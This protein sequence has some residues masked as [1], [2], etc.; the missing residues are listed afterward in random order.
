MAIYIPEEQYVGFN[1]R[2]QSTGD[3][4]AEGQWITEDVLLGF[5][6]PVSADAAFKKRKDTVDHWS[7]GYRNK[8]L[9]DPRLIPKTFKNELAEGFEIARSVRRS[10]WN[11]GNV[12][13]RV[14]DP[15]GFELEISS[16]NFASIVDCATIVNGVIQGRCVWGRDGA[17]NV[18]LPENSEPYQEFAKLTALKNQAQAGGVGIRDIKPGYII[19]LESG[20]E[21]EYLGKFHCYKKTYDT[22]LGGR[23]NDTRIE[24]NYYNTTV[25]RFMYKVKNG[26]SYAV[27]HASRLKIANIVDS[28]NT[29]A[30]DDNVALINEI[31]TEFVHVSVKKP[32]S[33]IALKLVPVDLATVVTCITDAQCRYDNVYIGR[34]GDE[35]VSATSRHM[36][37]GAT[38]TAKVTLVENGYG[39]ESTRSGSYGYGFRHDQVA[40]PSD[41]LTKYEWFQLVV[42][43][44]DGGTYEPQRYYYSR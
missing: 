44:D 40:R 29:T 10:G 19:T 25:E 38:K 4:N 23:W 3:K 11:S 16:S 14:V 39:T 7:R 1:L 18:L 26:S 31:G 30:L 42:H 9:D 28:S 41:D 2:S 15:R 5:A 6:T 32:T 24:Y 27:Q 43:F 12:V 22:V 21:V 36:S 33:P 37:D 20:D 35:Y 8:D 13:W 17:A 34:H